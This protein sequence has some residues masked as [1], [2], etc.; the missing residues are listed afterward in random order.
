MVWLSHWNLW[1]DSMRHE[2]LA[3]DLL[4]VSSSG[5]G[6]VLVQILLWT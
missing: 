6:P 4:L 1:L 3:S 2:M 5:P